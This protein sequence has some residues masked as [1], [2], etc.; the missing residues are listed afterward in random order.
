MTT[1]EILTQ[2]E[3]INAEFDVHRHHEQYMKS[4]KW[5]VTIQWFGDDGTTLKVTK[6]GMEF[7]DVLN[8][9]WTAFDRTA[10]KGTAI[11][12]TGCANRARQ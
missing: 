10:N 12:K 7:A 8:E 1:E 6:N 3:A 4:T 9:A 11:G 5:F 2:I